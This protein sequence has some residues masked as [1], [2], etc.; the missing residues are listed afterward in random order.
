MPKNKEKQNKQTN[1]QRINKKQKH[2][3]PA[4]AAQ[5]DWV[6]GNTAKET[7]DQKIPPGRRAKGAK[8]YKQTLHEPG[9]PHITPIGIACA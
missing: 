6:G 5:N 7:I 3:G 8:T 1:K 4:T 9:Q 2:T